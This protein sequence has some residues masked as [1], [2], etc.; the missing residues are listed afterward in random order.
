MLR[1]F[2]EREIEESHDVP[3]YLFIEVIGRSAR[4]QLADK[5][6]GKLTLIYNLCNSRRIFEIQCRI[7]DLGK[8][9]NKEADEK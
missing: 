2:Q 9:L 1:D 5:Y 7:G 4:K 8:E 6:T 3:C